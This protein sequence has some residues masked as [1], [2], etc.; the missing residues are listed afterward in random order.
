M[1]ELWEL[2]RRS[3]GTAVDAIK[4]EEVPRILI[5]DEIKILFFLNFSSTT[6]VALS[7]SARVHR[8]PWTLG[9]SK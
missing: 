2:R 8:A 9:M 4:K 6:I 5:Y 3:V 1:A 7:L